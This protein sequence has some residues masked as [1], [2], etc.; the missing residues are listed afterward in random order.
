MSRP[1]F[2]KT[3]REFSQKFASDE[4]CWEYL[5]QSRWPEGYRCPH[6]ECQETWW[7]AARHVHE[8]R[9]CGHQSYPTAGTLMHRTHLPIQEWFWAAYLVSTHTPG[10]SAKQLQ[11]QI[12]CSYQTAWYVL[13]RLRRAMVNDTRSLLRGCIEAD[14][15]IVGGPVRGKRGRGVIDSETNTLVFG[16]V[17]VISYD[18]KHGKHAEKAGRIRFA[19]TPNASGESIEEFLAS[20]VEKGSIIQ[21]DG[22]KGYSESALSK[23]EHEQTPGLRALHIHRAFGNLK[24]WLNGTHHGVDPKYL[25]NYLDEFVFR[26]NRRKTP[27]AAFQTLLGIA[28]QKA[29]V[30]LQQL[31]QPVSTG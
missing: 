5:W 8:C 3:L 12:S 1:A 28:T 31:T 25:Q 17:E 18:D 6:C 4:A 13:H 22:W 26:F 14:E 20:N 24:T 2:P 30:P 15:T 9:K 11:R 21:T 10:M 29:P 23:Y 27:M 19:T 16:A 7:I